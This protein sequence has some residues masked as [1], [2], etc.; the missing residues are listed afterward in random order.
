MT[1]ELLS[2]FEDFEVKLVIAEQRTQKLLA[3]VYANLEQNPLT[4]SEVD[5]MAEER[6]EG[7]IVEKRRINFHE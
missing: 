4:P 1:P 3:E 5:R 7:R 6:G 2:R